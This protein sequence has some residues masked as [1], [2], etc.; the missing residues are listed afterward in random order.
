[1]YIF[2]KLSGWRWMSGGKNLGNKEKKLENN[3]GVV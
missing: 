3:G 2:G 1:L